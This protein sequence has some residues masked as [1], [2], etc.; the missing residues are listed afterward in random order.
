MIKSN[1]ESGKGRYDVLITPKDT[2]QKGIVLEFKVADDDKEK[3]IIK[4]AQ[5]ALA[6]IE[7]KQY[8]DTLRAAGVKDIVKMGIAFCGKHVH[9]ESSL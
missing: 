5:A 9:I 6:Q 1:R 4:A 2:T 7:E 3:T 8:A